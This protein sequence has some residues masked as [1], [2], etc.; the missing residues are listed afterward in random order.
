M[1]Y[2][3]GVDFASGGSSIIVMD[4]AKSWAGHEHIGFFAINLIGGD[5][6]IFGGLIP[7]WDYFDADSVFGN[8]CL[9]NRLLVIGGLE[10]LGWHLV[11]VTAG[12]AVTSVHGL[13]SG[14][15][16]KSI[17]KNGAV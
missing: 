4:A 2:S 14:G 13:V 11:P 5:P 6:I 17:I 7:I 3:I 8:N 9:T 1:F 15:D 10:Y 16:A 12:F